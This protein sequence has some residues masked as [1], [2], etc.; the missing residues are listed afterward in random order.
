MP[1]AQDV[2]APAAGRLGSRVE[3]SGTVRPAGA[4]VW[5]RPSRYRLVSYDLNGRART[6]CYLVGDESR[7]AASIGRQIRVSGRLVDRLGLRYDAVIV[8]QISG[9]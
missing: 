6:L 1:V 9:L 4:I 3:F 5:R 2:P 8:E 7:L